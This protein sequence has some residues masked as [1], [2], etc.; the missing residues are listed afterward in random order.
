MSWWLFQPPSR[1]RETLPALKPL[2]VG[3][4]IFLAD[5]IGALRVLPGDRVELIEVREEMCL[6]RHAARPDAVLLT[7]LE[8]LQP[9]HDA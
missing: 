7:N 5:Q 1:E 2:V 8:F 3:G 4:V 9:I 6:V